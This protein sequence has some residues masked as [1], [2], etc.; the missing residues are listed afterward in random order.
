MEQVPFFLQNNGITLIQRKA[1]MKQ[2]LEVEKQIRMKKI[3]TKL[4]T[5]PYE[6][7]EQKHACNTLHCELLFSVWIWSG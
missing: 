3:R 5:K 1:N 6:D 7:N 4:A 2:E